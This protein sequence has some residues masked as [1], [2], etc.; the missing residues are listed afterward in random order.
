MSVLSPE[1]V[2]EHLSE[3]SDH[4]QSVALSNVDLACL[5]TALE[6]FADV[7]TRQLRDPDAPEAEADMV[8]TMLT[9]ATRLNGRLAKLLRTA[10]K[11]RLSEVGVGEADVHDLAVHARR[12]MSGGS[13]SDDHTG[14]YL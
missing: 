3:L 10:V 11:D 5:G 1:Q 4:Q 13:G 6:V 12:K 8:G 14:F 9:Q 7:L 2:F